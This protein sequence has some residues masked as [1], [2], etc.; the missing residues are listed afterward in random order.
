LIVAL[1]GTDLYR[2]IRTS[3]AAQR[4][5][6][7]ADR[8]LV[9]QEL[10]AQALPRRYRRKTRVVIQSAP[11]VQR[12]N[13]RTDAFEVCVSGHLRAE[14]DPF[15]TAA[16]LAHLPKSSRIR[17]LHAGAAYAPAFAR[18]A[19]AWAAREPR[20]R[21]LGELSHPRALSLLAR[22]R[23][24][25]MSSRLEGGANVVSEALVAGVPVIASRI[26]GN[27]GLLGR[28]YAGYYPVEN[29]RA[30][31]RL[32][33]HAEADPAFYRK[34]AAQCRLRR[35]LITPARERAALAAVVRELRS[36]G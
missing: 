18:Q 32:L 9:L 16:A 1:T 23:L 25:V 26:P 13:P 27:V 35:R 17:V 29:T 22:A 19:R 24:L 15:R 6:A 30:L 11:G 4:S 8:L 21:W 2:D 3:R 36:N 31:A 14:K 33:R 7:L 28:D 12:G 5:L 34:L 10:G 20:Y